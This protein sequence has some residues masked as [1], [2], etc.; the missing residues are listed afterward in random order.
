MVEPVS[1]L[2]ALADALFTVALSGVRRNGSGR[3]RQA[4]RDKKNPLMRHWFDETG[5]SAGSLLCDAAFSQVNSPMQKI[6]LAKFRFRI[7]L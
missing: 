5:E 4:L 6:S 3:S 2:C 1:G 7:T